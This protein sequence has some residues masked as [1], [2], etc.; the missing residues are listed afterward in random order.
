M[1][2]RHSAIRPGRTSSVSC[3]PR[4]AVSGA[5]RRSRTRLPGAAGARQRPRTCLCHR[6]RRRPA[7][8]SGTRLHP[9]RHA[10]DL[11]DEPLM[12][13][14]LLDVRGISKTFPG[15]RALIDADLRVGRGEIVG[16]AG[17]NGSGKSTLVK[18][19]AGYHQPDGGGE[20]HAFG[21]R[22]FPDGPPGRRRR[23]HFIHQD[24]GLV[25][26]LSPAENL[27]L[28]SGYETG[29]GGRISWRRQ[30]TVARKAIRRFGGTFDVTLPVQELTL[31]ERTVV[32]IARA[33][34]GWDSADA[35]LIVD[36]PTAAL[37]GDEAEK[38]FT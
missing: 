28:G 5:S 4:R 38:L 25:I 24:L 21:E 3:G 16:L 26:Q 11:R 20:I 33:M 8:S 35:L 32:A 19:L 31:A 37:H 27:A 7:S 17:A 6:Q 18:I 22:G 9:G 34:A 2:S 13:A 30:S 36:E 12:D 14:P 29:A 15:Q 1:A 23:C 10:R